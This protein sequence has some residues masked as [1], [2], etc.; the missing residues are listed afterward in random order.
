MI[1]FLK[2]VQFNFLLVFMKRSLVLAQD[3]YG[4]LNEDQTY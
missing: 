4:A 3:M 1:T 2:V